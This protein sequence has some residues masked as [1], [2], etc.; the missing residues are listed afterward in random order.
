MYKSDEAL[1][2]RECDYSLCVACSAQSTTRAR[3]TEAPDKRQLR[4]P[5][6]ATVEVATEGQTAATTDAW[7]QTVRDR[8]ANN[9]DGKLV[10][11]LQHDI[12]APME[13]WASSIGAIQF[14]LKHAIED[15][16]SVALGVQDAS[17]CRGKR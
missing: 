12:S 1:P 4:S 3:A 6:E 5:A 14:K 10:T 7:I 11:A 13:V 9:V 8:P 15:G 17:A 2:G 16:A